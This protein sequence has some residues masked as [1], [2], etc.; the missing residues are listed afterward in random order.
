MRRS[1]LVSSV[2][3]S[4]ALLLAGPAG[5]TPATAQSGKPI[6]IGFLAPLT[7]AAAQIGAG[8]VKKLR[9]TG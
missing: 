6:K 4:L 1:R 7:G 5:L 3:L 9:A 8:A 2:L